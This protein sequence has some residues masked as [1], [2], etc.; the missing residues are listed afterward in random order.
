MTTSELVEKVAEQ[1][2]LN[3]SQAKAVLDVAIR[4]IQ[5]TIVSNKGVALRNLGKL[6][7][8]KRDARVGRNPSTGEKVNIP[9]KNVVKFVTSLATKKLLNPTV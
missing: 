9:A 8:V 3:K 7:C 4:I 6:K 1:T 5:D 2:T